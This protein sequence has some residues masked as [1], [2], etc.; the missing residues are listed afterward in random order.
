MNNNRYKIEHTNMLNVLE[1]RIHMKWLDS[2]MAIHTE[3]QVFTYKQ[4][5]TDWMHTW[6]K[7]L[8]AAFIWQAVPLDWTFWKQWNLIWARLD[9]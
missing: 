8:P 2:T 7:F 9:S 5:K 3:A 6:N 4:E 1:F